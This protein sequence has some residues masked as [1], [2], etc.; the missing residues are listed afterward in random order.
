MSR[1]PFPMP[2]AQAFAAPILIVVLLAMLVLPL[3]PLLLDVF[4]TFNIAVALVVLLVSSY[5]VKPLDFAVFP[6]VLLVSTM[7]RLG[8]NVASTRAVLMHGHTGPD[9]AGKVIESFAHFLIGGNFAVGII[10]FAILTVINFVVV[11]KGAGRIAEVSAR[12]ALDAMPGK[13]MA[14]D[15]ELGAG[16]IDE[17]EARRRRQEVAQEADF[18]GSMDGA[19]KFV[20]GDAIAAMLILGINVVGGLAIGLIQHDL[21]LERAASNYVLL[22]I[23]DALVAQIPGLIISL[24]AGLIVSRVGHEDDVGGQIGTQLFSMPRALGLTAVVLG[25]LGIIPGMPH[26]AFLTL[27]G[28]CGWAAWHLTR[29][30]EAEKVRAAEPAEAPAPVASS[31]ASWED[32]VPVD[33]L[34]LEVGYRLIPM[35]ERNQA[36]DLLTRIKGVRKKFASDVGFLPPAIHIKDNLELRPNGYR[37][38]LKGA[39]IGEGEVFPDRFLAI[40]PGHAMLALPGAQTVDPAFGLP[41]TWI[42]EAQRDEAQVAGYTVVDAATVVATH[43]N[44]LMGVHASKLLGRAEVQQLVDH[45]AKYAGKLAEETV[46][47]LVPIPV[48]QKVLQNLLDESVHVRDLRTIVEALAEH[49]GRTQDAN[50]LTREVRVALAPAI[51]DQI[52][53]PT[54]EMDVIAFDPN[55]ENL[56]AQALAPGAAGALEPGVAELVVKATGEAANRQ[57]GAGVPACL[58]VPDRI[59]V[60]VARLVKKAAPRL[61]VL[62]HAEIPD[63]HSIRI[64]RIIGDAT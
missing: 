63:T 37:V 11:T 51:V 34:G 33:V 25:I 48:L 4:F 38:T 39:V 9:A 57:E 44:H 61:R 49:G 26:F 22:A 21:P 54:R 55:L 36:S 10:V 8:L 30:A 46:P 27:A 3:P 52:Y 64:G 15:A 24:A 6:T 29:R 50:E 43:L 45:L 40:N 2:R 5:T 53:G 7:L 18:F 13:Q 17:K 42:D 1:L 19:S 59:R 16:A 41:A 35:I 23:G 58:L 12:F 47:K 60:P 20:R 14:I 28:V 56:L 32:V 62:G 31:E